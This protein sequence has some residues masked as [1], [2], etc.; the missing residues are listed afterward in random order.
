VVEA[1]ADEATVQ[2]FLE[3]QISAKKAIKIYSLLRHHADSAKSFSGSKTIE[4]N[5]KKSTKKVKAKTKK[6]VK[7]K[8]GRKTAKKK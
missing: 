4:K 3:R 7:T 2:G 1:T 6:T 8:A 5:V